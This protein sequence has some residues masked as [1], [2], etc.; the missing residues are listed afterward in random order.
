MIEAVELSRNPKTE[1]NSDACFRSYDPP[2]SRF[3]S[4][5]CGHFRAFLADL[6]SGSRAHVT[7]SQEYIG[8]A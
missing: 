1:L 2:R 4:I 6:G 3:W 7:S 5:F 8:V